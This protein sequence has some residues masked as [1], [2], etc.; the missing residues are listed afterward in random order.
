VAENRPVFRP[1]SFEN[2]RTMI[3]RIATRF[4]PW[5]LGLALAAPIA[6]QEEPATP[7][8]EP[9]PQVESDIKEFRKAILDSKMEKDTEAT[10]FLN[11][12][13]QGYA[14]MHAKD[15]KAVVQA[16]SEVFTKAK[17]RPEN[18]WNLY[19]AT[20]TALGRMSDDG[21]KVLKLAFE[22]EKFRKVEWVA[23][24]ADLIYNLGHTGAMSMWKY[25]LDVA[26]ADPEDQV[27]AKAGQGL[28][29]YAAA[30]IKVRR[31]IAKRLIKRLNEIHGAA[32]TLD[33]GDATAQTKAK[34]YAAISEPW[35][36]TL[37]KLTGEKHRTPQAWEHW[38]NKNKDADWGGAKGAGEKGS[39]SVAK[40]GGRSGG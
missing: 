34:T 14:T 11:K 24:R 7:R 4:A 15:Q 3:D 13:L 39:G 27:M 38:W 32:K 16:M 23:L 37:E 33:L 5:L 12:W 28:G 17:R 29:F 21:A 10:V 40:T 22:D 30:D 18:Q 35:N 6:A 8:K 9:D 19:R 20:A 36:T 25:V 1:K 31:E 26:L 2:R